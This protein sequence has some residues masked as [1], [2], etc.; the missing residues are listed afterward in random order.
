MAGPSRPAGHQGTKRWFLAP[1]QCA[2]SC[3]RLGEWPVW[4][5]RP[6][7]P[8]RRG[9]AQEV[10]GTHA[11]PAHRSAR[12][13]ACDAD[14]VARCSASDVIIDS[15]APDRAP[16]SRTEGHARIQPTT[17]RATG[18]LPARFELCVGLGVSDRR[19]GYRRHSRP[20]GVAPC[21]F[22]IDHGFRRYR[23]RKSN[24]AQVPAVDTPDH[25]RPAETTF[26]PGGC[27][28]RYR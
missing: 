9:H 16:D 26:A 17:R 22:C 3:C 24:I 5:H 21:P 13:T 19:R 14:R 27:R 28:R 11:I 18:N 4:P 25:R 2:G 1:P 12:R 6:L 10:E 23:A 20:N 7:I 15:R 8:R